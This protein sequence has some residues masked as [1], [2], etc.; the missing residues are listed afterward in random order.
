MESKRTIIGH[1]P[2]FEF[3]HTAVLPHKPKWRTEVV[4]SI[5]SDTLL[6]SRVVFV[7]KGYLAAV[8]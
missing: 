2:V 7:S 3:H 4:V 5:L 8:C 1:A 6:Y